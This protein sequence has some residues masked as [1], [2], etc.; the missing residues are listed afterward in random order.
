MKNR[1]L[2]TRVGISRQFLNVGIGLCQR[3]L[4]FQRSEQSNEKE[5]EKW[6]CRNQV[7]FF[8]LEKFLSLVDDWLIAKKWFTYNTSQKFWDQSP[9]TSMINVV[10]KY[11][12]HFLYTSFRVA[13]LPISCNI[14]YGEGPDLFLQSGLFQ[15]LHKFF[16]ELT[17]SQ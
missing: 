9:L 16:Q 12:R 6:R 2:K 5:I 1:K 8:R 4:P 11:L 13:T 10:C 15:N 3:F 17:W 7:Q 14:E